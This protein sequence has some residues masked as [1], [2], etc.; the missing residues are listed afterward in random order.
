MFLH[1][2]ESPSRTRIWRGM[3]G[4]SMV[5]IRTIE[6]NSLL[7]LTTINKVVVVGSGTEDAFSRE[8]VPTS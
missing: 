3:T 7:E 1:V 2:L 8:R 5:S 4:L 6:K